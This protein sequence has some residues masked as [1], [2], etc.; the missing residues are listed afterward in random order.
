[1]LERGPVRS[2]EMPRAPEGVSGV[3]GDERWQHLGVTA[4]A[5]TQETYQG[6]QSDLDQG[7]TSSWLHREHNSAENVLSWSD[8]RHQTNAYLFTLVR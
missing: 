8:K 1:M 6:N 7:I 3:S 2:R 4:G 5:E